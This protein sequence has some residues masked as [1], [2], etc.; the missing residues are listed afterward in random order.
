MLAITSTTRPDHAAVLQRATDL[1]LSLNRVDAQL[2]GATGTIVGAGWG[3]AFSKVADKVSDLRDSYSSLQSHDAMLSASLG[4]DALLAAK[5]SGSLSAS[6][7]ATTF[8]PV[9]GTVLDS[10]ISDVRRVADLLT[11]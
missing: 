1:A 5:N 3:D 10:T 9:W 11:R 2:D 7:G 8:S 4:R 6:E